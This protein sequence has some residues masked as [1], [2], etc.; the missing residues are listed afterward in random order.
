MLEIIFTYCLWKCC[1]GHLANTLFIN[2]PLS[3]AGTRENRKKA[4]P[5][6]MGLSL[7]GGPTRQTEA[8]KP[9]EGLSNCQPSNTSSTNGN[10]QA[11]L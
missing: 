9:L 3:Y 1:Y 8:L 2:Y 10:L 4:D 6:E 11:C 7:P 5:K